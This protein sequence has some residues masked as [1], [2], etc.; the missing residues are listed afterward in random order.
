MIL[1]KSADSLQVNTKQ[2]KCITTVLYFVSLCSQP[3]PLQ[4]YWNQESKG[5]I[6]NIFMTR[7]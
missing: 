6:N 7:Y 3:F 4:S 5:M 2:E 1:L